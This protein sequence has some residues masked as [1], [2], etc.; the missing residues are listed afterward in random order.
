MSIKIEFY[1]FWMLLGGV[2]VSMTHG[3]TGVLGFVPALPDKHVEP[4]KGEHARRFDFRYERLRNKSLKSTREIIRWTWQSME[5]RFTLNLT[6]TFRDFPISSGFESVIRLIIHQRCDWFPPMFRWI[7]NHKP[8]PLL[9]P[10]MRR[11]R[12]KEKWENKILL[13][14]WIKSKLKSSWIINSERSN[15][16]FLMMI[17]CYGQWCFHFVQPRKSNSI[18][19]PSMAQFIMNWGFD[20]GSWF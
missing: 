3:P 17:P 9:C 20:L 14:N 1:L 8:L 18:M 16:N 10:L 5:K 19:K 13:S 4:P 7:Y 11:I 12:W 2:L 6:L 15:K